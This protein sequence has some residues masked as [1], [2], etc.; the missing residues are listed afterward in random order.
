M[1]HVSTFVYLE[2]TQL[3]PKGNKLIAFNPMHIFTPAYVPGQF[4]FAVVLGILDFDTKIEHEI[5]LLFLD[6]QGNAI[7]DTNT[8][9]LPSN[10]DNPNNLPKDMC[11][12]M[13]NL[14]FRNVVFSMEGTYKTIIMFDGN[15]LGEFPI[16]VKGLNK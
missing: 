2:E 4:S 15:N 16:K 13:M 11:G 14:D 3:D 1:A 6:P 10:M 9:R 12:I 7:I 5:K 8:I